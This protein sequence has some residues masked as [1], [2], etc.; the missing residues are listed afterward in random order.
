MLYTSRKKQYECLR[1]DV[2]PYV[3][4]EIFLLRSLIARGAYGGMNMNLQGNR[5]EVIIRKQ[6]FCGILQLNGIL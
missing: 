1:K 2:V 6:L 3:N 4:P 5:V